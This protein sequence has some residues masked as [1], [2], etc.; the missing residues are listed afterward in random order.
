MSYLDN[1]D[2]GVVA[3]PELVDDVW[4]LAEGLQIGLDELLAAI[5]PNPNPR[6]RRLPS[7]S[8]PNPT[9]STPRAEPSLTGA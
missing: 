7:T 9:R 5:P 6:A 3:C 4:H 8:A 1:L 2:F